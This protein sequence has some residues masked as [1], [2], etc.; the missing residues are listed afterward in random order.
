MSY[1]L[2]VLVNKHIPEIHQEE[3][4]YEKQFD[5]FVVWLHFCILQILY[6]YF[7]RFRCL[8]SLLPPLLT[9]AKFDKHIHTHR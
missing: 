1:L 9:L 7:V 6:I 4:L 5:C 2:A 3:T 8:P